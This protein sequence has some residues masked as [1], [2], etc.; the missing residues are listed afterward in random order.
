MFNLVDFTFSKLGKQ[1][2]TISSTDFASLLNQLFCFVGLDAG[3]T[4][5][6]DSRIVHVGDPMVTFVTDNQLSG[7]QFPSNAVTENTI[8]TAKQT[9]TT[10]LFTLLDKYPFVYD[11]SLSPAQTLTAGTEAIV[12]VCPDVSQF[13]TD[14][15]EANGLLGRLVLGHQ[16]GSDSAGFALLPPVPIPP[17]MVLSCGAI[18]DATASAS[19]GSRLIHSL[20]SI[21]LPREAHASVMRSFVGGVGGSTSEFS[22]FGTVDPTLRTG[23]VG[24]STS[25]FLRLAPAVMA[26][27]DTTIDGTVG[28]TTTS[29]P[30]PSV[31]I[32]TYQGTVIP[33]VGVNFTAGAPATATPVGDASVWVRHQYRQHRHCRGQ[34]HRLRHHGAVRDRI[35]Q[36][37]G[38]LHAATGAGR[39]PR[40][41]HPDRVVRAGQA[42]LAGGEPPAPSA[43]AFTA[44]PTGQTYSADDSIPARVEDAESRLGDVVTLATDTVTLTLDRGPSG[45]ARPR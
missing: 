27:S 33:G 18:P 24:G 26:G 31:T 37:L 12:G 30:L 10:A 36:G 2:S 5:P 6:G 43:L 41:R 7:I 35:H 4:D 32:R 19:W 8:V 9:N 45:A 14:P 23:G 13:P 21:V 11:W 28:S 16:H 29:D 17:E 34:L 40:R 15:A 25:E 42:E 1:P 20:A 39:H 3:I 38:G 44:P 22:S